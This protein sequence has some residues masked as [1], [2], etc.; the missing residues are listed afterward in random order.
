VSN[1]YI[2]SPLYTII[3]LFIHSVTERAGVGITLW[4]FVQMALFSSP[5]RGI[6]YLHSYIF[7]GFTQPVQ[8]NSG[9]VPLLRHDCFLRSPSQFIIHQSANH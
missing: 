2:H 7:R 3:D 9:N 1:T 6:G 4:P 8:A 5:G